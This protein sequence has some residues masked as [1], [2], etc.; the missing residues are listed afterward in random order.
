VSNDARTA[1]E[2]LDPSAPP[3]VR[4]VRPPASRRIAVLLGAFDPPTNAH[5]AVVHAAARAG[6]S[7]GVLCLT[8]TLLA[9][10]SDELLAATD[11]LAVLEALADEAGLGFALANRGTYVDVADAFTRDGYDATFVIGSDKLA[12]LE[13]PSFYDDGDAGVARTFDQVRF[14]VVPRP[15]P[16]RGRA[17]LVWLEIADVFER[18]GDEDVSATEVRRRIRAGE[19]VGDLVPPTVEVALEGYTS[20]K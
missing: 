1:W 14:V 6:D 18:R 9:R 20:A 4:F 19:P 17:G 5:L 3:T 7:S 12:Q 10:P 11:R 2:R 8:K 16:V 13:D 15:E